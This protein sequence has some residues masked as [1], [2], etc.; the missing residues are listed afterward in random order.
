MTAVGA[1]FFLTETEKNAFTPSVPRYHVNLLE[2]RHVTISGVTAGV[3]HLNLRTSTFSR[4]RPV[5]TRR[6]SDRLTCRHNRDHQ[7]CVL[8]ILRQ[9]SPPPSLT[10]WDIG[11]DSLSRL[12]EQAAVSK[13]STWSSPL[14]ELLFDGSRWLLPQPLSLSIPARHLRIGLWDNSTPK[15]YRKKVIRCMSMKIVQSERS[16]T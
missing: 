4:I 10:K 5:F 6:A 2:Q 14:R 9:H 16:Q 3:E 11:F 1:T 7:P 15:K 8:K 13:A 12:G